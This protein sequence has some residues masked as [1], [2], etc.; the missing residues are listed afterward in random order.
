MSNDDN[1]SEDQASPE[2]AAKSDL[3]ESE[4]PTEG[5]PDA[6]DALVHE[7]RS[8]IDDQIEALGARVAAAT[9]GTHGGELVSR[10]GAENTFDVGALVERVLESQGSL[11]ANALADSWPTFLSLSNPALFSEPEP[12][13]TPYSSHMKKVSDFFA[14]YEGIIDSVTDLNR[15]I[16]NLVTNS[17]GLQLVWRGQQSVEWGIHSSLF[18]ALRGQ[19]GVL[20]P[21]DSPAGD[22]PFPTEDQ[23]VVAEETILEAARS[24]WRFDGTS[25]LETFARIQHAG[26]LTRLL[27]VTFNPYIAAWFATEESD[28]H[29]AEDGRLVAFATAPL[30]KQG[31]PDPPS[32]RIELDILWGGRQPLWHS[33]ESSKERQSYDWGTGSRR[34]LWVPPAYDPRI[35]AQNAAFLLDGI[36]ITSSKTAPYFHVQGERSKYFKRADLLAAG[37]MLMRTASPQRKVQ[38][39]KQ[40]MAPT[41]PFRITE[42]AK[43]KIRQHL[44]A[45]FGY[46]RASLYPDMTALARYVS[47]ITL[48]P[49]A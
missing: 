7:P 24:Q 42:S 45:T 5:T 41:F 14:G 12:P 25:A 43:P 6:L 17:S 2:S 11:L 10:L 30:A 36:P 34:R 48:P 13:E 20:A 29:D 27:D 44:E 21:D 32:S 1:T 18:R 33:F 35:A 8:A 40:N 37:S 26:G 4:P 23:M 19:N 46:S 16:T 39:N 47:E 9:L 49:L 28:R 31:E 22:Q 15:Y 38:Y 3:S